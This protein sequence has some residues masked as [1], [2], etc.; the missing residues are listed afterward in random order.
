MCGSLLKEMHGRVHGVGE[1][2]VDVISLSN[3]FFLK[4]NTRDFLCALPT[5][6]LLGAA[7]V[8]WAV[9]GLGDAVRVGQR[10]LLGFQCVALQCLLHLPPR[11]ILVLRLLHLKWKSNLICKSVLSA[12]DRH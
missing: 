10:S 3:F 6:Q 11:R 5:R 7:E 9:S 4:R 1:R 8:T 12:K 2:R